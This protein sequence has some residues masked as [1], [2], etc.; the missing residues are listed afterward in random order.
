MAEELDWRSE[1][2]QCIR[3]LGK[4]VFTLDDLYIFEPELAERHPRNHHI[5][6]KLRQQLQ[7]LRDAGI[8]K[9]LGDGSYRIL[10]H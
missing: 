1:T 4:D 7:V 5:K 9:F 2:Q 6:D 8:I 3:R 10:K